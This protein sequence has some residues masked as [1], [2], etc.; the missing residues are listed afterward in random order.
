MRAIAAL[1]TIPDSGK[2]EL[3]SYSNKSSQH[4]TDIQNVQWNFSFYYVL[5]VAR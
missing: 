4:G 2:P 1:L 3:Y 5:C